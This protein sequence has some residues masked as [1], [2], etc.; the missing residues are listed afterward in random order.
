M[1]EISAPTLLLSWPE[2]H[3]T[4]KLLAAKL[5]GKGAWRGIIAVTRGG[6]VPAAIVARELGVHV[7]ETLCISSYDE[8]LQG[9]LSIL[10]KPDMAIAD[11]RDGE[12][13]GEGWI[14]IDDLTDTGTT[15]RESR[16]ILPGAHYAVLYVKPAGQ[17]LVDT[18]MD[19]VS[20]DTWV[21][22]PWDTDIQYTPPLARS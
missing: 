2:V 10:K 11:V 15:I 20:Q 4:A 17:I 19:A 18:F 3:R 7:I 12:Q 16:A 14:V 13:V 22:F 5:H 8:Q 6:M 21:H 1:T 9:A